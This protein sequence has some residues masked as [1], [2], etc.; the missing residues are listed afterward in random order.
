[1]LR[2]IPH[3]FEGASGKRVIRQFFGVISWSQTR[4]NPRRVDI[5]E[6][7]PNLRHSA[8]LDPPLAAGIFRN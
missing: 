6:F 7:D 3:V 1:M 8:R 5:A 4:A 2:R